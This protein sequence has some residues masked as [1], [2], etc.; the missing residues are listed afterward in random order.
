MLHLF[1]KDIFVAP[2]VHHQGGR[3]GVPILIFA[4]GGAPAHEAHFR[5]QHQCCA[6]VFRDMNKSRQHSLLEE[7]LSPGSDP[8]DSLQQRQWQ[9][10]SGWLAEPAAILAPCEM[11]VIEYAAH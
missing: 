7:T 10:Q 3:D 2:S 8:R 1:L 9:L 11:A 4:R 5:R 6:S